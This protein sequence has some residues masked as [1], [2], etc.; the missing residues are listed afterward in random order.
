M[1]PKRAIIFDLD[2]TLVDSLDDIT[3]ALNDALSAMG[4][5]LVDRE[6]VRGWVGDGLPVLCRRACPGIDDD[7]L[8]ALIQKAARS[9][10][11]ACVVKTRPYGNIL[12]MLDLLQARGA[13][14]AVLSNKPHALTQRVVTGLAMQ[15]YFVEV[16]GYINEEEK[17]PAP[18]TALEMAR[19]MSTLPSRVLFVGD[20]CVDIQT[21]RN[22]GMTP[23]SVTWGFQKKN[24]LEGAGPD[25]FVDDPM[26]IFFL[27][28][29]EK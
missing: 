5:P 8:R 15:K 11:D 13:P 27:W 10:Q 19:R 26:E 3:H 1:S 6:N 9:Y 20:S 18:T 23:V 28:A 21:A 4:K 14:M 16:R 7:T 12:Q 2:G 22:A 25:H 29:D 17:K 24:L